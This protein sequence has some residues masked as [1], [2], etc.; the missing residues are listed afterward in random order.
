MLEEILAYMIEALEIIEIPPEP[1]EQ[2]G[3]SLY[4]R[5]EIAGMRSQLIRRAI[6]LKKNI[7]GQLRLLG[8]WP[9]LELTI[10]SNRL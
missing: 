10:E 5:L 1:P 3:R 7:A 9:P 6:D 2:A 8:T 4:E